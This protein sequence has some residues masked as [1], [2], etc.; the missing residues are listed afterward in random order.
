MDFSDNEELEDDVEMY[1]QDEEEIDSEGEDEIIE[2]TEKQKLSR[3]KYELQNFE[4]NKKRQ[5]YIDV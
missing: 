3:I 1:S 5:E 4:K 2:E